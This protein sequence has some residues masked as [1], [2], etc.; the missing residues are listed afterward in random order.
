MLKLIAALSLLAS[1]SPLAHAE[2]SME[3][4]VINRHKEDVEKLEPATRYS[5]RTPIDLTNGIPFDNGSYGKPNPNYEKWASSPRLT[6]DVSDLVYPY[7]DRA[8]FIAGCETSAQFVE[9]AIA[10]WKVP[11]SSITKPEV[12]EARTQWISTMQPLL[13]K[14]NDTVRTL[15]SAGKGDWEK[16]QSDARHALVEM[17]STYSSLYKNVH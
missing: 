6:P 10:N 7:S 12:I 2:E 3:D 17:R 1:I 14:F 13:D 16:A 9:T 15:K 8:D 4:R 5:G 11:P